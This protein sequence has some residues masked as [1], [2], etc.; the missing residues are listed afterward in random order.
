[1]RGESGASGHVERSIGLCVQRWER[2]DGLRGME[3]LQKTSV[4]ACERF[5]GDNAA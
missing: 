3:N 5:G 4:V 2:A 1:M